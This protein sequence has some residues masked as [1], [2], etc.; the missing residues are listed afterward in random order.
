MSAPSDRDPPRW[1]DLP[2]SAP[3]VDGELGAAARSVA[4]RDSADELRVAHLRQRAL[5]RAAALGLAGERRPEERGIGLGWGWGGWA[6]T[7]AIVL[8]SLLVGGV[9]TAVT[10]RL[11]EHYRAA[12]VVPAPAPVDSGGNRG[13]PRARR[14]R[15]SVKAPTDLDVSVGPEGAEI[16][17]VEGQATMTGAGIAGGVEVVPG[18]SWHEG[19]APV[20]SAMPPGP[21]ASAPSVALPVSPARAVAVAPESAPPTR[22]PRA[23]VA[24][25]EPRRPSPSQEA[26]VPRAREAPPPPTLPAPIVI[27][28]PA[29]SLVEPPPVAPPP[30]PIRLPAPQAPAPDARAE[31]PR[32]EAAKPAIGEATLLARA[33]GRLR[34]DHDPLWA[35]NDL[36]EHRRRFPRGELQR[37]AALAR[38][39]ALLAMDRKADALAVLDGLTLGGGPTGRPAA[40]ARAELRAEEGRR[41]EAI[42]DFDRVIAVGG[43]DALA[44]RALFGRGLCHLRGGDLD[45]ARADLRAH[46]E[47]FPASARGAEVEKLLERLGND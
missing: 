40:L 46:R 31:R 30:I 21:R 34:R 41:M 28:P 35:L 29:P 12:R 15:V 20:A 11:M 16:A 24:L 39:E 32:P 22:A 17:V 44:D 8:A 25:A 33:L 37:E 14:W 3:G 47:R 27:G 43:D 42:G 5:Q 18:K 36:D 9:A 23:T 45:G 26:A 7:A 4:A 1:R 10:G 38:A 2:P 13:Q 19:T 6:R